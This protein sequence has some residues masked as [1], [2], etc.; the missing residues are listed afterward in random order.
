MSDN[1]L[2]LSCKKIA[3][4]HYP[5]SSVY[6]KDWVSETTRY[7]NETSEMALAHIVSNK[8][9]AAYRRGNLYEKRVS[10]MNDWAN[11]LY[12]REE[13]VIR[14]VEGHNR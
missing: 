1:T 13:K 9:E 14:L 8:V 5:W 12:R 4:N 11:F 3:K 2:R 7:D 10:L 6:L